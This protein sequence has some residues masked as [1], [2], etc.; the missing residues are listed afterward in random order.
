MIF[1]HH[2]NASR[3]ATQIFLLQKINL[4]LIEISFVNIAAS[5]VQVSQSAKAP[6]FDLH[7]TSFA[8]AGMTRST[9]TRVT[10]SDRAFYCARRLAVLTIFVLLQVFDACDRMAE[11]FTKMISTVEPSPAKSSAR[12]GFGFMAVHHRCL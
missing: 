5:I 2:F 6:G 8:T 12:K 3:S 9:T 7:V 11:K 1:S 4:M 10:A